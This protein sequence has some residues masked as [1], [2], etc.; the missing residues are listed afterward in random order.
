MSWTRWSIASQLEPISPVWGKFRSSLGNI[1]SDTFEWKRNLVPSRF[2]SA[3]QCSIEKSDQDFSALI[4]TFSK[5]KNTS[6]G[7]ITPC[8][9]QSP[10]PTTYYPVNSSIALERVFF[11]L[12]SSSTLQDIVWWTT[13][14]TP[15][16]N[17]SF[18]NKEVASVR[19]WRQVRRKPIFQHSWP[20]VIRTSEWPLLSVPMWCFWA[21]DIRALMTK[22]S[23][24]YSTNSTTSRKL[25]TSK[26]KLMHFNIL[27]PKPPDQ[28]SSATKA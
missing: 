18:S 16:F 8:E 17:L 24:L 20:N 21:F 13:F 15:G 11:F 23:N 4:R 1:L 5:V 3:S 14:A 6:S 2:W 26:P 9:H 22:F 10:S 7:N 28:S 27:K 25:H 19:F 12:T